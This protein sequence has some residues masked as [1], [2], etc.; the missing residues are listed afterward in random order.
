M[1]LW[2]ICFLIGYDTLCDFCNDDSFLAKNAT[3]RICGAILVLHPESTC[4]IA[5]TAIIISYTSLAF[6]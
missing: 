3:I 4:A 1:L 2:T 6:Q 5:S